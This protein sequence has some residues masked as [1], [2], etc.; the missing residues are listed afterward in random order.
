MGEICEKHGPYATFCRACDT[1]QP[2][3]MPVIQ[4]D[5]I[6]AADL[7][8]EISSLL[9]HNGIGQ[10][11]DLI[12]DGEYDEHE[13]TIAFARHRQQSENALRVALKPF[14]DCCEYIDDD[15]SDEE[16]AKFRLLIGD[17]RRARAALDG[18]AEG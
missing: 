2:Q 10:V 12:R 5:R 18:R 13:A 8:D 14:A 7:L 4:A 6:A 17:Y 16:W 11:A 15:E 3:V 9:D 1:S